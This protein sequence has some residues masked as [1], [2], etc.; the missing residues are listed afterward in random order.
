MKIGINLNDDGFQ[1][2]DICQVIEK[3]IISEYVI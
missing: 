1:Y 3:E 2:H